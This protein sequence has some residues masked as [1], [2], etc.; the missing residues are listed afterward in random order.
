LLDGLDRLGKQMIFP[1]YQARACPV[2]VGT[3]DVLRAGR[4]V[5]VAALATCAVLVLI[6]LRQTAWPTRYVVA[7]TLT[8]ALVTHAIG[9]TKAAAVQ[10]DYAPLRLAAIALR[11]DAPATL[12]AL[13]IQPAAIPAATALRAYPFTDDFTLGC[14]GH[15]LGAHLPLDTTT[16]LPAPDAPGTDHGAID[17]RLAP[18]TILSG[19]ASISGAAPDCVLVTDGN[20]TIVGGGITGLNHPNAAATGWH[21]VAPPGTTDLHIIVTA[22]GQTY[23]IQPTTK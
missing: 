23:H 21:A 10:R 7:I 8:V 11:I 19:W 17:T 15:E 13:H 1:A 9:G 20:G 2:A 14:D 3:F 22:H 6:T 5:I 16:P 18:D 12:N 4:Y